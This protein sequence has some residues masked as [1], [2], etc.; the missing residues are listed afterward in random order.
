MGNSHKF[1]ESYLYHA[2]LIAKSLLLC[3]YR[4]V[5]MILCEQLFCINEQ[6]ETSLL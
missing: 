4:A 3:K 1:D 2:D 6:I 5:V